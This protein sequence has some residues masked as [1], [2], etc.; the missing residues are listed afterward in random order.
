M[1]DN[2]QIEILDF[3]ALPENLR[4]PG[5]VSNNGCGREYANYIRVTHNGEELLFESD[6]MEPEDARFTRDLKWIE[7]VLRRAY[8]AGK[9][10]ASK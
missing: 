7:V 4:E 2:F 6:A 8:E 9:A 3:D 1:A 10:D 5:M